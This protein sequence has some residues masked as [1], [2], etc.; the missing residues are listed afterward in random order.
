MSL[1]HYATFNFATYISGDGS[2]GEAG[3]RGEDHGIKVY[4]QLADICVAPA[5]SVD[6]GVL[7]GADGEGVHDGVGVVGVGTA[8]T[9]YGEDTADSE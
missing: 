3:R 9:S 4:P 5:E 7:V 2:S 6:A 1:S 8:T